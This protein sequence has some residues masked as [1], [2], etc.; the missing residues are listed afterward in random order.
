[1]ATLSEFVLDLA[2]NPKEMALFGAD[3][4]G[5]IEKSSLSAEHKKVVA[6]GDPQEIRRAIRA[7]GHPVTPDSDWVIVVV[8]VNVTTRPP[9]KD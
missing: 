5:Y 1:M 9:S 6:T 3:S 2:K 8:A 4:V 7:E